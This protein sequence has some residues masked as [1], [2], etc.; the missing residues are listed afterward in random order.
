MARYEVLGGRWGEGHKPGDVIDLDENAARARVESGD[1][2]PIS[3]PLKKRVA[4]SRKPAGAKG[5]AASKRGSR[6]K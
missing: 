5:S 4:G 6:K 2:K 1:L 3:G